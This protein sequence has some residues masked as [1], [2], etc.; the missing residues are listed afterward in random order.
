MQPTWPL[1]PD[2]AALQVSPPSAFPV[3]LIS[4][5]QVER[6]VILLSSGLQIEATVLGPGP[7]RVM[8]CS[9]Y[10]ITRTIRNSIFGQVHH[11]VVITQHES[12]PVAFQRVEPLQ[13]VAI[14]VYDRATLRRLAHTTHENPLTEIAAMQYMQNNSG[15]GHPNVIRQIECSMDS[16]NVFSVLEFIAEGELFEHIEEMQAQDIPTTFSEPMAR[17]YF[18]QIVTGLTFIHSFGIGHRDLSLENIMIGEGGVCKIIDFGMCLR[19]S[20]NPA[21]TAAAAGGYGGGD[22]GGGVGNGVGGGGA[23]HGPRALAPLLPPFLALHAPP[24]PSFLLIPPEGT[25]GKRNYIAPEIIQNTD[26][27]SPCKA[28]I[29]ALGV[30]LFI[31][32]AGSPPMDYA[33][34]LDQR[35]RIIAQGQLGALIDSW[36]MTIPPLA[37]QLIEGLLRIDPGQRPTAEQILLHPWMQQQP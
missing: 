26:P 37:Q 36:Q 16:D 27:F 5:A 17:H 6:R 32:L 28:D 9:F 23:S 22:G 1:S 33:C 21:V 25:C 7:N 10:E 12:N 30:I 11:A 29:W 14:K 18:R 13:Q 34:E 3:P 4:T 2:A 24:A 20:S 19:M 35:Y 31:M 15:G 8:P